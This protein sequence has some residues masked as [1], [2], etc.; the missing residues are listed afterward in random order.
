MWVSMGDN[1][2]LAYKKGK[3]NPKHLLKE[4]NGEK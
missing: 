2:K 4:V 1:N 3:Q